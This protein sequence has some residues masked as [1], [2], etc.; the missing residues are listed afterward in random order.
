MAHLILTGA[1]GLVGS[2]V[3]VNLIARPA[4]EVSKVTILGRREHPLVKDNP[5]FESIVHKDFNTY[6]AELLERMKGASGVIWAQGIS[7]TAV[8]RD[9]YLKITIDYP[10]AA[11]KSFASLSDTLRF[12]YVSG[13]GGFSRATREIGSLTK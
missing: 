13:D 12:V 5:R 8:P 2:A 3:L 6:D 7:I 4:T 11:A 9:E 10:L 1:T